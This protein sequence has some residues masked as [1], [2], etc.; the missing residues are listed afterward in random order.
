MWFTLTV[1]Y[2]LKVWESGVVVLL[3][4]SPIPTVHGTGLAVLF[5]LRKHHVCNTRI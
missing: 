4:S 3:D 5:S 1:R 2:L